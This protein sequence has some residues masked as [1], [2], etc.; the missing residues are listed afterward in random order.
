MRTIMTRVGLGLALTVGT[1]GV[2]AAQS[3]RPDTARP[4]RAERGERGERGDRGD[5]GMRRRG[6]PDGA[7]LRGITLTDAQKTQLATLRESWRSEMQKNREQFSAAKKEAR[8]A[9]AQGDTATARAKLTAL[10]TQMTQ[11]REQQIAAVRDILTAEQQ[12]QF[13]ANVS[14]LKERG[15]R[16]RRGERPSGGART[17]R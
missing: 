14:A 8:A 16:G 11:Q 13:D 15:E 12:K 17:G 3:T 5:R 6:G 4:E 10:R 7:L 1:A 2:V 9:R